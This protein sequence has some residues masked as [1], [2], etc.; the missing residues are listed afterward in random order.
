MIPLKLKRYEEFELISKARLRDEATLRLIVKQNNRRLFRIA[1]SI[2][3][4]HE[5]AQDAVQEAYLKAFKSLDS[6][7]GEASLATWLSRI[8]Y[9]EAL[10]RKQ[11]KD[12]LQDSISMV[13][14][15][16]SSNMI[17]NL[18]CATVDDPEKSL[19]Q[20]EM[21][22]FVEKAIDLLPQD[23]RI[24]FMLRSVEG[25]SIEE[26]SEI[27]AIKPE[28]IKTRHHRARQFIRGYLEEQSG[29]LIMES[30]PFGGESCQ[31]LTEDTIEKL[32]FAY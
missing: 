2:L 17:N 11:K 19:A 10:S 23:F 4:D 20:Q 5:E 22:R 27:L 24:V 29:P 25:L 14:W 9:N 31:R 8:A 18:Q 15:E 7:R 32:L 21:L 13:D 28:T 30:F 1:R 3:R 26:T 12:N 6:F 16:H